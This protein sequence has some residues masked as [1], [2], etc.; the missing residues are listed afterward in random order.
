MQATIG[1]P[2][3]GKRSDFHLGISPAGTALSSRGLMLRRWTEFFQPGDKFDTRVAQDARTLA[4]NR[5]NALR[6]FL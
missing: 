6:S 4:R 1:P 2:P 3:Q 5:K